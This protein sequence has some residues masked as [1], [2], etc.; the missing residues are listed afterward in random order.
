MPSATMHAKES[1]HIRLGLVAHREQETGDDQ[2]SHYEL[3]G[4]ST[5]ARNGIVWCNSPG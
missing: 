5:V 4:E 2:T 1:D 3:F